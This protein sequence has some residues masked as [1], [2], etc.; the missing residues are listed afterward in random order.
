MTSPGNRRWDR[1]HTLVEDARLSYPEW[2]EGQTLFNV[3]CD[4]DRL[5]LDQVRG[6]DL[7]PFYRDERIPAFT[8]YLRRQWHVPNEVPDV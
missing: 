5:T 3:A 8:A 6:T 4:L 1:F 2:R 7:D